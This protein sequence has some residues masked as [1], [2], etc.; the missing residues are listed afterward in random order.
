MLESGRASGG[1]TNGGRG[2]TGL[3][4]VLLVLAVVAL[5]AVAASAAAADTIVYIKQGNIWLANGDG[6]GQYQVTF[7]GSP[8]SPYESP[9]ESD[10][11]TILAIRQPPGQRNQLF[12]MTQSGALLNA[13]A[14][15]PAPGPAGAIDSKI[16]PDGSLAAYWFVTGV[17]PG[18]FFCIEAATGV[19]LSHSDRF[20]NYNEIGLPKTGLEPSWISNSTILIN[21][22]NG[23]QWYYT[24]GM[25]EGAMWFEKIEIPEFPEE[26]FEMLS[27]SE[28]A[29]TGDRMAIVVGDHKQ[30]I[31]ILKLNG[32]PPAKPLHATPCYEAERGQFSDT[33]WSSNGATLYFQDEEGVIAAPIA[34]PS[35]CP[36]VPE[37]VL[38][39]PGGSEPDASPAAN[40]PGPRPGCGNPGNPVACPPAPPPPPPPPPPSCSPC[41][42][43]AISSAAIASA[44]HGL[45]K[46]ATAA[47]AHSI[48]VLR[49]KHKLTLVF[50]APG[51]GTLTVVLSI[52]GTVLARGSRSFPAAGK[53]K[54]TLALTPKGRS[55]LR[56]AHVLHAT[57]TVSFLPAGAKAGSSQHANLTLH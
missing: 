28:V 55:R 19:L 45:L 33:T 8:S 2:R 13:P 22:S 41:G 39:I 54:L 7:D 38:L 24:I 18:C 36:P 30:Q 31:W 44:L 56:L 20:T 40:N 6:S 21:E 23:T 46:S 47:L 10:S 43:P 34:G 14:N 51:A 27:D 3:R 9:S 48:H 17:N 11:G 29:P 53:G 26:D 1:P 37:P 32:P 16:S 25:P 42:P 12:R 52:H 15:T 35:S 50:T 49:G 4:A 57:L 5:A